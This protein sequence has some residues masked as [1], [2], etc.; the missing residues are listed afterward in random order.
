MNKITRKYCSIFAD[1]DNE[2]W[3]GV[4]FKNTPKNINLMI[5]DEKQYYQQFI[6]HKLGKRKRYEQDNK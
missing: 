6:K 4:S 5:K 3:F 2:Q 1:N